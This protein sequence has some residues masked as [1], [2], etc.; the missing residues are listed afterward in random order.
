MGGHKWVGRN[1]KGQ[2]NDAQNFEGFS[3]NIHPF[4][5]TVGA[6]KHGPG[7]LLEAIGNACTRAVNA[8]AQQEHAF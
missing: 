4:P 1:G 7:I 3:G 2:A 8:L 6:Q 5:K